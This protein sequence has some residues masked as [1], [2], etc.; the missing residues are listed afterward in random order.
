MAKW[1]IVFGA[2][3]TFALTSSEENRNVKFEKFDFSL[4]PLQVFSK[5]QEKHENA[6]LLESIEGPK[7]LARYSF[8]GFDPELTVEIKNGEAM[9]RNQVTG[10]EQREKT[11]DPLCAVR[12]IIK[13]RT[14]KNREFR[15]TGGA[16]G[17]LSYDAV[18]YWEKLPKKT[19]DDLNFPD[20][21][22]GFFDDGIVFEHGQKRAVYY[23]LNHNRLPEI[24][25]LMKRP[26]NSNTLT[27][28]QPK[29]NVSKERFFDAV[30]EA[31][32]YVATGYI[33]Q[34]VLSTR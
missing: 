19:Q 23:Y 26:D 3:S 27:Y 2:E 13:D 14:V 5:I 32:R 1:G 11:D 15:F 30:T 18:R 12:K 9:I 24:A 17:F 28:S 20:A 8:I 4:T 25:R 16:V 10:E 34:V 22:F 21:Q 29:V 31:K 7:N 6:Y 33:F